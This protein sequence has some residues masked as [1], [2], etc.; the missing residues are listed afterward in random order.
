MRAILE[1]LE[2]PLTG[3]CIEVCPG[4]NVSFGRTVNSHVA[5]TGDEYMSGRHFAV[6]NT[7]SEVFI[8]DLGSANGT[9]VNGRQVDRT[10]AA[11]QDVIAAGVS[12]FRLWMSAK[13]SSATTA[14]QPVGDLA[15]TQ[16]ITSRATVG[17]TNTKGCMWTPST[18][19]ACPSTAIWIPTGIRS[20]EP[21][22]NSGAAPTSPACD[23]PPVRSI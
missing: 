10:P 17:P 12:K 3:R 8:Q 14:A 20:S 21:L 13:N 7:G 1:V 22:S 18:S 9:F 4:N 11:P 5:V 2:G 16:E 15:K 23:K 6:E 19:T